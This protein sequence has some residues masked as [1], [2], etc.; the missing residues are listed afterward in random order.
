MEARDLRHGKSGAT[1]ENP[2][3][4]AREELQPCTGHVVWSKPRLV[5]RVDGHYFIA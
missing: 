5:L 4:L 3:L 2:D 1:I